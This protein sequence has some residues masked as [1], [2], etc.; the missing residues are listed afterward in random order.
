M[1]EPAGELHLVISTGMIIITNY[2][3]ELDIEKAVA[4][5]S[6]TVADVTYT[7]EVLASFPDRVIVMRSNGK[8]TKKYFLYGILY[9]TAAQAVIKTTAHKQLT[10]PEPP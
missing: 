1:F 10:F 3:R 2:Y 8:Q 5:T 9:N 7:R 4:K 6:Y